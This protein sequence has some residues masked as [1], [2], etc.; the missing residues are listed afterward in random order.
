MKLFTQS[1]Y[2]G[3][4]HGDD[5]GYLFKSNIPGFPSPAIDSKEFS[6]IKRMVSFL[7]SFAIHGSPN[8]LENEI[9]WEPVDNDGESLKCLHIKNDSL[10]IV[11]FPD[12]LSVWNE[13]CVDANVP[14]Y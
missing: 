12:R 7:T 11:D 9:E 2:E 8:S 1:D 14:L 6:L 5:M 10:E 13:I 4:C 3:A